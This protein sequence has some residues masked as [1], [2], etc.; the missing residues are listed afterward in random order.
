[1]GILDCK[2]VGTPGAKETKH[3]DDD[4]RP[5]GQKEGNKMRRLIAI[6]NYVAQ[7]RADLG[8]SVKECARQMSNPTGRTAKAIARIAKYLKRHPRRPQ[9]FKWQRDPAHLSVYTDA[10]WAGCERTRK[11][12]SGGVIMRGLHTRKHWSKTQSGIALS[13]AES[14]LM[15]IIKASVE[16]L[17]MKTLCDEMG[18]KVG[19]KVLTDSAAAKGADLRTGSA[20][21]KH[22]QCQNLWVQEKASRGEIQYLKV[23]RSFNFADI[24]THHWEAESGERMLRAMGMQT[25]S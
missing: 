22:I 20:R 9:I 11:S 4:D 16:G 12:T 7:D 10:D 15:A 24:L 3:D 14:E 19:V 18:S 1:M 21:M 23:G 5:L 25:R 2:G 8:F 6:L 17:G 13:S